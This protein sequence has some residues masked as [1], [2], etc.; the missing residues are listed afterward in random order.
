MRE[1]TTTSIASD[2]PIDDDNNNA[3]ALAHHG[4]HAD[5]LNGG[6]ELGLIVEHE[7]RGDPFLSS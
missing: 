4:Q 7:L 5:L 1:R 2:A 3:I 6:R